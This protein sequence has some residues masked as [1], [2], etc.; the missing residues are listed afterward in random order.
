MIAKYLCGASCLAMLLA[1]GAKA[2]ATAQGADSPAIASGPEEIVV[3]ARRREEKLQNVPIAITAFTQQDLT[4]KR[5]TQLQELAYQTPS[6]AVSLNASDP[7]APFGANMR[8]RGL[9]GA[10]AYFSQVPTGVTGSAGG[11]GAI[12]APGN[13]YD[14]DHIEVDKGPQGTL[15]GTNA[16]GGAILFEPKRPTND[17]E[18]YGMVTA[19]NF[20]DHEFQGAINIP[21]VADKV[22]L[23]VAGN[24]QKRDGYTKVLNTG[25][26]LDDRD[27]SAWRV[28][29]TLR[30]TDDV[31]NYLVYDGYWQHQ[32][33]SSAILDA[34]DPNIVLGAIPIGS[35]KSLP[36]TLAKGPALADLLNPATQIATFIAGL[37]AGSFSF[38]PNLPAILAEQ[39]ALG[40]RTQV[41]TDMPLLSKA[42]I[43]GITDVLHWDVQDDL[44]VKNIAAVRVNKIL[45]TADLDGTPLPILGVGDPMN[46]QGWSSSMAQFTEEPQLQ[47][48]SFGGRLQWTVGGFLEF[49]HP[50][51]HSLGVSPALGSVQY[52]STYNSSRSQAAY[53]QGTYDLSDF[54]ENLK[55][56]AGYRYNWDFVSNQQQGYNAAGK[57]TSLLK[58]DQN[59]VTAADAHFEAPGW[60]L[61]LD[62]QITPQT[63][64]YVRSGHAYLAG[65]TELGTA[66]PRYVNVKPQKVTD[67][68]VGVKTDWEL[69]GARG[70]V[71]ADVFH[72]DFNSIAV[73]E[74]ISFVNGAGQIV[75]GSVT[76]NAASA[77]VDGF[78]AEGTIIPVDNV[79]LSP[80][81]SFVH[82]KY[83]QYPVALGATPPAVLYFPRIQYGF[84]ATY[85]LPIDEA[86]GKVAVSATYSWYGHQYVQGTVDNILESY[87]KLDLRLD[88]HDVMNQPF[89]LAFFMTNATDNI[90]A[91]GAYTLLGSIGID[92]RSYGEPRMWGFQVTYRFGGPSTPEEAPPAYVPPPVAAPAPAPKSYLV[93]FNFDKSDLTPQAVE[94]VNTAA[95]NAQAG[96]VTELTVTGHTDTVGSDAYNMRLSR[97]RAESVA[98]QLEKQGIAS[99][100]IA[101]VAKGKRDLL[102]PTGDGV[103]EPQNRRVQIV[104]DGGPTS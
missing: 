7:F 47:G 63:L 40:V 43:W 51:G 14:L 99:G 104:F 94:I 68:E 19:G 81:F 50:A 87:D 96:K 16:I 24:V 67:V 9:P 91:T 8:L 102:V 80:H 30:P 55:F 18:G 95:K 26:Y 32:N 54:V 15:F 92:T 93:F 5:I 42:Y 59:C 71:N 37:K 41:G 39:Q 69:L 12:V 77:Y 66:D 35:G 44:V 62:Y 100:E 79:E 21:I 88:W 34:I 98:A 72:T 101:I 60:T 53:A 20:A 84:T 76:A 3:T 11:S 74:T 83:D 22:L 36:L 73:G 31:E 70:R 6:L 28:G 82:S 61:G 64:L 33:G 38:Y 25:A 85:H 58:P 27:Q 10:V 49:T 103:R 52:S 86:F 45:S 97:R 29:L 1:G 13:Y 56:T 2:Q 57:C 46:P 4:E 90:Y 78:E 17:F 23:R 75:A 89:D 65:R 48:K